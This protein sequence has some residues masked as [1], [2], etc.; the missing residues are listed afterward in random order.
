MIAKQLREDGDEVHLLALF[1]TYGPGYFAMPF[2]RRV[3]LHL[4]ALR[5]LNASD[6]AQYFR[7]R[8]RLRLGKKGANVSSANVSSPNI[9]GAGGSESED[10]TAA[11]Q[12]IERPEITEDDW[13]VDVFA[14]E[15]SPEEQRHLRAMVQRTR[16]DPA[17]A[18]YE[19]D[20]VLFVARDKPMEFLQADATLGWGEY[21]PR[22]KVHT[23][24]GD[25]TSLIQ[26]P[27]IEQLAALLRGHLY[28]ATVDL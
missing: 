3:G 12:T 22:L 9:N 18:R 8:A 28:P 23:V 4:H 15:L 27:Y 13:Q 1:D 10:K 24:A 7:D 11:V 25:H 21:A 20:T 19:G 2:S 26:E 5:H 14:R 17:T 16:R 6:R